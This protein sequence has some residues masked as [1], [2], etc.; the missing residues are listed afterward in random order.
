MRHQRRRTKSVKRQQHPAEWTLCRRHTAKPL[1]YV[2]VR[3]RWYCRLFGR[4]VQAAGCCEY[5]QLYLTDELTRLFSIFPSSAASQRQAALPTVRRLVLHDT[6]CLS[7][8]KGLIFAFLMINGF[9]P[10]FYLIPHCTADYAVCQ[11]LAHAKY[12]LL[13]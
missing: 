6:N 7:R 10:F 8:S 13:H 2:D 9:L 12:L 11:H 1:N 5:M 4:R 3:R